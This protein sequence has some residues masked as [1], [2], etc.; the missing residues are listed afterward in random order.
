MH[1]LDNS[2]RLFDD[3]VAKKK[4]KYYIPDFYNVGLDR[5]YFSGKVGLKE[6]AF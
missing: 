6:N 5:L 4:S 3:D 2:N 1:F